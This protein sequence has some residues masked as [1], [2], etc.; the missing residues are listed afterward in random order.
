M[1]SSARGGVTVP[2]MDT[3]TVCMGDVCAPLVSM[4]NSAIYVS[5]HNP[6]SFRFKGQTYVHFHAFKMSKIAVQVS[7]NCMLGQNLQC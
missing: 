6:V 7:K 1:G 3:V 4:A 2:T 5:I